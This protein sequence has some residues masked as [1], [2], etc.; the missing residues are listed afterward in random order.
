M[1]NLSNKRIAQ[2]LFQHDFVYNLLL[3]ASNQQN[4]IAL[5]L[6]S[7]L[8]VIHQQGFIPS[9]YDGDLGVGATLE[10]ALGIK[11]NNLQLPDYKGIE[12]KA[13]RL[14]INGQKRNIT[15]STLFT[16]VPDEGLTYREIVD[17]YGK[18]QTPKNS[19]VARLQLYDTLKASHPNAY[20]LLIQVDQSKEKLLL[21]HAEYPK[22]AHFIPSGTYL[23]KNV[24]AWLIQNLK[25][26]LI[27][28]HHETF[29]VQAEA[30]K[31][32]SGIEKFRYDL[33]SHT[34]QPNTSLLIP[35]FETDKIT[36]DL[37]AHYN[38]DGSWRDHGILF[39][40][41]PKDLPLLLGTP[42]VYRLDQ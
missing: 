14:S 8:R 40:M 10:H 24:S 34:R 41:K 42:K 36:I 13:T 27:T 5:E 7:K 16:K 32:Q 17:L 3:Q 29:W 23:L 38:P 4:K 26:Q 6:L 30:I 37:A 20:D 18:I 33:V 19:T 2:S 39:K 28:K 25:N 9:I 22:K 35:L 21:L 15:R 31:D 12:L 11:A 1:I